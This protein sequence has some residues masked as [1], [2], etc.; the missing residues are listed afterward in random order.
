MILVYRSDAMYT[1]TPVIVHYGVKGMRWYQHIFGKKRKTGRRKV[2]DKTRKSYILYPDPS[3]QTASAKDFY[4][5]RKQYT[6]DE[7]KL[8][9]AR[10]ALE[11]SLRQ[12]AQEEASTPAYKKVAKYG[13]RILKES[14]EIA[15]T[16]GVI[17]D[18][19]GKYKK[20]TA[21]LPRPGTS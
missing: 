4:K 6:T 16:I 14:N 21:P 12:Y 1:G 7:L 8:I 3:S 17:S 18:A 2:K 9:T 19:Y 20:A 13:Q 11:K 10:K 5:N 15:K